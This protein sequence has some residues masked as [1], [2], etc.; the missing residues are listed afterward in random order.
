MTFTYPGITP[1]I[2]SH[3]N[4]DGIVW[5]LENYSGVLRAFSATDL[6]KELYNSSQ[7]ANGRDRAERGVQFYVPT[8]ANGKVYFGS[9]AHLYAYGLLQ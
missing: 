3:G 5:A 2:S 8:V 1:V 4:D 7:A 9:R 6:A